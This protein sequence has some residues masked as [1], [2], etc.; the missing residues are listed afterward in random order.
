MNMYIGR[1]LRNPVFESTYIYIYIHMYIC[2]YVCTLSRSS[3]EVARVIDLAAR[4]ARRM[5]A[6]F[7]PLLSLCP[8]NFCDSSAEPH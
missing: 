5:A 8:L 6:R 1:S 2:I 7:T 4:G 3:V